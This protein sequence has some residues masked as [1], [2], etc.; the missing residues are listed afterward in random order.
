MDE[1]I[2]SFSGAHEYPKN[3]VCHQVY[4][5]IL[6]SYIRK[7]DERNNNLFS[8]DHKVLVDFW[9]FDH[10]GQGF[11]DKCVRD[12]VEL[13]EQLR[14]GALPQRHDPRCRFM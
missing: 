12:A 8:A 3:L 4:P 13:R 5:H 1:L 6:E 14:I 2:R 7:L 9:Q 10:A 11:W